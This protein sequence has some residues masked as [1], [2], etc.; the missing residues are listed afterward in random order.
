[1]EFENKNLIV[2]KGDVSIQIDT[3]EELTQEFFGKEYLEK[4]DIEKSIIRYKKIYPYSLLEGKKVYI[5]RNTEIKKGKMQQ[6]E[7]F[8]N[9][10]LIDNEVDF[11]LSLCSID[12]LQILEKK[13]SNIF[14][15]G[16]NKEKMKGNY[17]H[18]NKF[19]DKIL[20]GNIYDE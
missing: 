13:T 14:T 17:V 2:V 20:K 8:E 11:F 1:M 7:N 19:A 10:L 9:G 12:Y 6:V 15:K 5:N 3:I 4:N 16:I 18:V